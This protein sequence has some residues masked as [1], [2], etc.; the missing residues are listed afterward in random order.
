MRR[1]RAAGYRARHMA[2]VKSRLKTQPTKLTA[3]AFLARVPDPVR[4]GDAEALVKIF[5][6]ATGEPPVMWGP[7]IVGFGT[8]HYKYASGREGDMCLVGFAPRSTA[9]VLYARTGAPGEDARLAKLGTYKTEG[10]CLYVKRLADVDVKTLE[11]LVRASA[12]HKR[13]PAQASMTAPAKKPAAKLR[14]AGA[15]RA[16]TSARPRRPAR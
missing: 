16:G 6:R 11:A 13:A 5:E 7:S 8:H 12:E 10:G 15:A 4:R 2:A 9:L 1:A 14:T 3:A